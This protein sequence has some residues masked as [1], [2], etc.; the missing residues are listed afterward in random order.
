MANARRFLEELLENYPVSEREELVSRFRS[1][2]NHQFRSAEFELLVH[3]MLHRLGFTLEPHPVLPN[4]SKKRPD[5]LVSAPDGAQFYLEAVLAS[6]DFESALDDALLGTALDAFSDV[7]K[8]DFT[9]VVS[10]RGSATTQ[11][12]GKAMRKAVLGWLNT[13]SHAEVLSQI[14]ANGG[15]KAPRME[16]EHEGLTVTFVAWPEHPERRG[17][18]GRIIG[19]QQGGGGPIDSWSGMRD[20]ILLKGKKYG[21]LQK[22]LIVAV[23]FEG[24]SLSQIDEMQALFGQEMVT[25]NIEDPDGTARLTRKPNGAWF[26]PSGPRG[27]VSGAWIF[28]GFSTYNANN[29]HYTLYVNP[30]ASLPIPDELR[31]FPFAEGRGTSELEWHPGIPTDHAF[32][33][34]S[35]WPE[36]RKP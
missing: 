22:P 8:N 18:G 25:F 23:N 9:L 5:F 1:R 10:S 21:E 28:R 24:R 14:D 34:G 20:A 35:D 2:S 16:W 31:M 30:W 12:S 32:A 26:G 15:G 36:L 27:Y 4:G 33:L 17:S 29:C 6:E 11:P 7:Q 19:G 13:L 3:G